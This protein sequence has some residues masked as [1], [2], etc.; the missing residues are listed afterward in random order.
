VV[1]FYLVLF[2]VVWPWFSARLQNL[3][4]NHTALGPHQMVSAVR[5]RDLLAITVT[6]FIGIVLT[7]GFFKPFADIRL[8]RYRLTHMA[9][10]GAGNLDEFIAHEQQAVTATGEETADVF[11]VDISF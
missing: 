6:N 3:V 2:V 4:W 11:D 1:L 9:L 8:A 10:I 5:A 7:L